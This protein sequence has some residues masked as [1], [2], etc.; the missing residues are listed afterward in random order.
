MRLASQALR[1]ALVLIAPAL[2]AGEVAD[3]PAPLPKTVAVAAFKNGLAFVLRQGEIPLTSGTARIS[4]IPSAT[5]G[6][7]WLAPVNPEARID[8]IV[9]YRYNAPTQRPI[10]TIGEILRANA[11]KTVTITY[12]MKEYT[13]EV[14][15][16]QNNAPQ[17]ATNPIAPTDVRYAPQPHEDYLLLRT[18]DKR[19]MAF[20]LGGISMANLPDDAVLHETVQS[21]NQALRLKIK[22]GG[23]SEKLSM[24]YLEHGLGWTPSYLVSLTDDRVRSPVRRRHAR[25]PTKPRQSRHAKPSPSHARARSPSSINPRLKTTH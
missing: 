19:L 9:A 14:V 10:Q 15:G 17:P 22:G 25:T 12:Q 18:T 1:F 8:E 2:F 6:T 11:G 7:L 20:P 16:L 13:G 24:G 23:A 3:A 4:P 21:P 5:L